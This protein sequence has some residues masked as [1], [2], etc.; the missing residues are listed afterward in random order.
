MLHSQKYLSTGVTLSSECYLKSDNQLSMYVQNDYWT[1]RVK[2]DSIYS[3]VILIDNGWLVLNI[4]TLKR[5]LSSFIPG[6]W[7]LAQFVNSFGWKK[8][9]AH[10]FC[11]K[12]S[13]KKCMFF[14]R[15]WQFFF[16]KSC[17]QSKPVYSP[18]IDIL[19]FTYLTRCTLKQR[20]KKDNN[21]A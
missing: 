1:P 18:P 4:I 15:G 20:E 5:L 16:W 12:S 6:Q 10:F 13:W 21:R 8:F 17:D 19:I 7:L 11:R 9:A 14:W 3:D 2:C